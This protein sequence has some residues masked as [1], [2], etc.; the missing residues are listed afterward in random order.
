MRRLRHNQNKGFTL[1]EVLVALLVLAVAMS[2]LQLR[3]GQ[4][5]DSAA[6]LRDKT[7][8]Q[9][10]AINQLE[11]LRI[12]TRFGNAPP[13]QPLSGTAVM[14]GRTWYWMI[15]PQVTATTELGAAALTSPATVL[16]NVS[17]EN[18]EAA[19]SSPLVS[20]T[21]VTDAWHGL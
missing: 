10:V 16:I 3:I 17:A 6:Y 19:R 7:I 1:I 11:L 2:A 5:L 4:T 21:G 8:A 13:Q 14:A 9:W 20:L 18:T 12:A 15:T